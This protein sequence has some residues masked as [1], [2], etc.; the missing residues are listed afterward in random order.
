MVFGKRYLR[1]LS[2]MLLF[3]SLF[4]LSL[5]RQIWTSGEQSKAVLKSLL[6]AQLAES[7]TGSSAFED[8]CFEYFRLL[9]SIDSEWDVRRFGDSHTSFFSRRQVVD[10][11]RHMRVFGHCFIENS[12]PH[13]DLNIKE[14]EAKVFPIFT[15]TIPSFKR[16][17]GVVV[18]GLPLKDG[19]SNSNK[20]RSSHE[21]LWR[22]IV[23][24]M[25]GRGIV[26]SVGESGVSEAK[27]LLRVL[28]TLENDLPI[29]VVHKGDLTDDSMQELVKVARSPI[30]VQMHDKSDN[31]EHLQEIWFVDAKKSIKSEFLHLFER[32]SNKW[33]ASLF[34]SFEEMI[35]LDTDTVPF[36]RPSSLFRTR[37]YKRTGAFFFRDRLIEEY[38]KRGDLKF[39]KSLLPSKTETLFFNFEAAEDAIKKNDFFRFGYKHIM[40]SGVVVLRRRDHMPGLLISTAL[41]LWKETNETFYGDKELFWL[42]QSIAGKSQY[43][44]NKHPAGA[45]GIL[46]QYGNNKITYTC[47]TQPGHFDE[48]NKLLWL[49]GGAKFC[50]KPFWDFDFSRHK[51]LRKTYKTAEN[52]R[53]H[54][55]SPIDANGAVIPA[56]SDLSLLHKML[57]VKSGFRKCEKMGCVGYVWCAY[58]RSDRATGVTLEFT[59]EE[60]RHFKFIV[61]VWNSE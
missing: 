20:P 46:A 4:G 9:A 34:N 14:I 32:F 19:A 42:G 18:E 60:I 41:N 49:N 58:N 26:M 16:W 24:N 25:N 21:S 61:S 47:S 53:G 1:L 3:L 35:L 15:S 59:Q 7:A 51:S 8:S 39:F 56:R 45:V 38:V 52:L 28:Q 27:R 17:D 2:L 44:F 57:G 40:E 22:H 29:Q 5:F 10:S 55:E 23:N 31:M 12:S 43:D 50:K 37:E 13:R 11:V 6:E 54:Y 33:I 36:V 30:R 48:S